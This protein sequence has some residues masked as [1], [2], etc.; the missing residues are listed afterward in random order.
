MI[1]K[2]SGNLPL[3]LRSDSASEA[4]EVAFPTWIVYHQGC[5]W[6]LGHFEGRID[7][8]KTIRGE[9]DFAQSTFINFH[10]L[11]L[12]SFSPMKKPLMQCQDPFVI[13]IILIVLILHIIRINFF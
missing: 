11:L 4:T 13:S 1:Y 7:S 2:G 9:E 5:L 8:I 10:Y 6:Y 12:N 3:P